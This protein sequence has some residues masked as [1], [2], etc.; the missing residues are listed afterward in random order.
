[1]IREAKIVTFMERTSKG[2]RPYYCL[3]IH[4]RANI[5]D[6][7]KLAKRRASRFFEV[8]VRE[9]IRLQKTFGYE[10]DVVPL[11]EKGETVDILTGDLALMAKLKWGIDV[12]Y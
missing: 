1:M 5:N 7:P 8:V 11:I 4:E 9:L 6:D 12:H 3:Y 2:A 10:F